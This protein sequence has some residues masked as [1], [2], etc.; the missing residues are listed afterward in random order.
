M[1]RFTRGILIVAMGLACWVAPAQSDDYT[2]DMTA[3][4]RL[5]RRADKAFMQNQR[6]VAVQLYGATIKA[7]EDILSRQGKA[8]ASDLLAVRIAYCN[9]Q[10]MALLRDLHEQGRTILMVTHEPEIAKFSQKQLH[11]VDGKIDCIEGNS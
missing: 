11:M 8:R 9:N 7:Y 5:L 2:N 1:Q 10:I 6:E 3:T 4:D